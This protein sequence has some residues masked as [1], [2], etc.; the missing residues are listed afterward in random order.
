MPKHKHTQDKLYVTQEEMRIKY[1]ENHKEPT[2][3]Y[4]LPFNYCSL[5]LIPLNN[6]K[7]ICCDKEGNLYNK[8]YLLEYI[9][10]FHKNP[11]SGKKHMSLKD[12]ISLN[13]S[14]DKNN[15]FICPVTFKLLNDSIKI[16][17]I[18]ETGNVFSFEAYQELNNS[19]SNYR[20]LLNDKPFNKNNIIILNDPRNR[21]IVKNF[22]YQKNENEKNYINK[23]VNENK[24]YNLNKNNL[25]EVLLDSKY[26]KIIEDNNNTNSDNL[27]VLIENNLIYEEKNN[28]NN[29]DEIE[30]IN[31]YNN[32]KN[33]INKIINIIKQK[34]LMNN[35][36]SF[37]NDKDESSYKSLLN[38]S[39]IGFYCYMVKEKLW[40]K[41]MK[42]VD[43]INDTNK[44]NILSVT[45]I[46]LIQM[47]N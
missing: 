39:Y 36:Y 5:S 21:K 43:I 24:D 46:F 35:Y 19:M 44:N 15:N 28:K 11:I 29:K 17:A 7:N 40:E 2:N 14:L 26:K 4:F 27:N 16:M 45:L 33:Q 8:F 25:I 38:F 42:N 1:L 31:E 12:I 41:Y 32:I 13:I 10:K 30:G 3:D 37:K 22:Y 34:C 18:P 23:L 47:K 9:T 20:D 6:C